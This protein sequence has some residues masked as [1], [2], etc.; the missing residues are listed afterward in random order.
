VLT[1]LLGTLLLGTSVHIEGWGKMVKKRNL[2][3]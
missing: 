2:W 3:S 1:A